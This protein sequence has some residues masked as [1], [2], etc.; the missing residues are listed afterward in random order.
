M[1]PFNVRKRG[2]QPQVYIVLAELKQEGDEKVF[3]IAHKISKKMSRITSKELI[4]GYDFL[5]IEPVSD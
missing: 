5:G 1:M 2:E 3:L 4:E